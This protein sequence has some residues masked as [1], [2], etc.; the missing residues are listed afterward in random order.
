MAGKHG[1]RV[2]LQI[3]LEPHRAALLQ[4][5]ADKEGKRLTDWRVKSSTLVWR[6]CIPLMSIRRQRLR[7]LLCGKSQFGIGLKGAPRTGRRQ[8]MLRQNNNLLL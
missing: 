5:L 8:K 4:G 1:R 6:S 2:Y 3:L 7:M